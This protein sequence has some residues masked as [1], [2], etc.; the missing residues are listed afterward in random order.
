MKQGWILLHRQIQ[1]CWIWEDK[2]FDKARAWIDLL[3]LAN[4]KDVRINIDG[5]PVP[6]KRGQLFTSIEKLS[7][8]WGWDRKTVRRFLDVL[9]ND[10][11]LSRESTRRGTTLSIINYDN[12]Q[13]I[14][15]TEGTSERTTEG[16]P[17]GT[18]KGTSEGTQTNNVT[19]N[20]NNEK[21]S[22]RGFSPP[23][24]EEVESYCQERG[25]G[26]D[27][28]S[29][30][31]FY[32]SKGWMVGKNKMKDWKASVRTWENRSKGQSTTKSSTG[33]DNFDA[34]SDLYAN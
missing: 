27:P 8:R 17:K 5:K 32:S 20:V 6:I 10:Q 19:N 16:T 28:Q 22:N 30:I 26:V 29:F 7:V 2:P 4:H 31:D 12:F 18:P 11:M 24:L 15:T 13:D 9:E 23:S 33:K 34:Y 21:R 14:G 25:N 1:E 3:L